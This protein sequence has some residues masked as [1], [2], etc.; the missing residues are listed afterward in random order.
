[1]QGY[2]KEIIDSAIWAPSGDNSQPWRFIVKDNEIHIFNLPERDNPILNFRQSGSYV[3]HGSLIENMYITAQY[4]GYNA[5]VVLFPDKFD[6]NLA[7]IVQFKES[8]KKDA[9]LYPYIKERH[10]NRK[11]Y[12]DQPLGYEQKEALLDITNHF[13]TGRVVL[14]ENAEERKVIA[15]SASIM[16]RIALETRTL[17]K[18]FF[19]DILWNDEEN[20]TG[21]GG[22]YIKTL[23]LPLP[24]QYAFRVLKYWPITNV[25]N[26]IGFS[27]G[28]AKG[29]AKV[30]AKASAIGSIVTDNNTSED[31]ILAGRLMQRVWLTATKLGLSFQPVTGILFLAQRMLAG[32]TEGFSD[33]HINYI[34]NAYEQIKSTF[35]I[36][37]GTIAMMFRIGYADKPSARSFRM[38]PIIDT[39][40]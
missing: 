16:E 6:S 9:S 29:N 19:G 18:L 39:K 7:A 20:R 4:F 28:A 36:S 21:K 24:V 13:D 17:H 25:L 26:N 2:I 5:N 8:E 32:E 14:M 12:R 15:D 3:A 22:L 37:D 11:P 38:D 34:R 23:E 30:Y 35:N 10:T 31:F 40:I 27:K 33:S 1:M